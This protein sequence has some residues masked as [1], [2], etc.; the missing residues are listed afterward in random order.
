MSAPRPYYEYAGIRIYH[1]DCID[2]FRDVRGLDALISDPPAGIKLMGLGWDSDRGGM[3]QWIEWLAARMRSGYDACADDA[4]SITWALPRTS[5]WTAMAIQKSGWRIIDKITHIFSQ[6]MG[7]TPNTLKPAGE[8]WI[9][10]V[11]GRPVLNTD[12]CRVPRGLRD[13]LKST[14]SADRSDWGSLHNRGEHILTTEGSRPTNVVLSHT[15]EC[16]RVGTRLL[17]PSGGAIP[18]NG[19]SRGRRCNSTYGADSKGRSEWAG[20][21][22][23]GAD[24]WLCLLGCICGASWLHPAGGPP[25]RCVHCR[26]QTWWACAIAEVDAQTGDRPSTLT[27]RA[28]PDVVHSN[29]S[30]ARPAN[31]LGAGKGGAGEVYADAG[32]GSRFFPQFAYYAKAPAGERHAG[33][34][35]LLW[36]VDKSDPFRYRRIER[37]EYERLL[38][39][40]TEPGELVAA[41]NVHK[42]VKGI[43]LMRWLTRLSNGHRIGDLFGGSGTGG[44]AAWLE[45]CEWIGGDSAP[46]AVEI[47]AA[48]LTWWQ[49]LSREAL[50]AATNGAGVNA[51]KRA[52]AR[53]E[54]RAAASKRQV[55][56]FSNIPE[57]N[58]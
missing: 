40:E 23:E 41:F 13:T 55:S 2:V 52:Q 5:H 42:T 31:L 3:D 22:T 10:A 21:G 32:G 18:G 15:E 43:A 37:N 19:K 9:V 46:Q 38:T 50:V 26:A 11:K 29:P 14:P 24:A 54:K 7:K 34:E 1:G 12:A 20:Y 30:T 44:I 47:A 6:G 4:V 17:K 27:G 53:T 28:D 51:I 48:R 49:S 56:M 36:A 58:P 57:M 39:M 16:E 8:D 25:P 35:H 45:G 33:C